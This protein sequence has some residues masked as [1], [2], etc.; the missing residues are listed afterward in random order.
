MRM[1]RTRVRALARTAVVLGLIPATHN[2]LFARDGRDVPNPSLTAHTISTDLAARRGSDGYTTGF[3]QPEFQSGFSL[4]GQGGWTCTP[5]AVTNTFVSSFQPDTGTQHVR[6]ID[7]PGVPSSV[8]SASLS[9]TFDALSQAQV[10]IRYS[11]DNVTPGPNGGAEYELI[12]QS[13]TQGFVV[14]RFRLAFTGDIFVVDD[15][16]N[17]PQT[18]DTG[19]D[20][21]AGPEYHTLSIV[22]NAT[23][24]QYFHDGQLIYTGRVI[25]ATSFDQIALVYDNFQAPE[26]TADFDNLLVTAVPEPAALAMLTILILPLCRC[27]RRGPM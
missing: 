18:I 24:L 2:T 13:T 11:I 4:V 20:W 10:S 25:A 22:M 19:F 7:N 1:F 21:S 26:E 5:E 12:P 9:P 23:G 16:G 6:I 27:G 3:E 14:T 8:L 15:I 17:G